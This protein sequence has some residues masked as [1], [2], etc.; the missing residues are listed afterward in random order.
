M[1]TSAANKLRKIANLVGTG[2]PTYYGKLKTAWSRLNHKQRGS[3]KG[4]LRRG[5]E[6]QVLAGSFIIR[7]RQFVEL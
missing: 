2:D 3:L 1:N 6:S 4:T 7:L 5:R